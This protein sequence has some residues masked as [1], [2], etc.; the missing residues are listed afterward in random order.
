MGALEINI[1]HS[2]QITQLCLTASALGY[3]LALHGFVVLWDK[4]GNL[5]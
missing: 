2:V 5:V 4:W 1:K 3:A